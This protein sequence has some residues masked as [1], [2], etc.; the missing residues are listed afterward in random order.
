[1]TFDDTLTALHDELLAHVGGRLHD[2]AALL[3]LR[4]PTASA[5][6]AA[7]PEAVS[8]AGRGSGSRSVSSQSLPRARSTWRLERLPEERNPWSTA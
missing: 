4:K 1:M 3:L 5:S 7:V 2:D 8:D 6:E